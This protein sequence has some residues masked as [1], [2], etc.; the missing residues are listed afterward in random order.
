MQSKVESSST[1]EPA[2][3]GENSLQPQVN[4]RAEQVC[5]RPAKSQNTAE[6]ALA[7]LAVLAYRG[8]HPR[9]QP[10]RATELIF[11][12]TGKSDPFH[13][14]KR[15]QQ[16]GVDPIASRMHVSKLRRVRKTVPT[17]FPRKQGFNFDI[18]QSLNQSQCEFGPSCRTRTR[19]PTICV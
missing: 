11:Q 14:E 3:R 12:E 8:T 13:Q 6:V 5:L 9:I 2:A 16:G 15:H 4:I 10:C 7:Q 1:P 19:A 17:F 18:S